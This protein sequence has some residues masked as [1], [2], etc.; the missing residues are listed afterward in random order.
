MG[1]RVGFDRLEQEVT[2]PLIAHWNQNHYVVVYAIKNEKVYVADPA[3]GKVVYTKAEFIKCWASTESNDLPVGICLILE[4]TPNFYN[5]ENEDPDKS[6][7]SF[8]FKYLKPHKKFIIQL[9]LGFLVGSILQLFFPFL[10]QAIVDIGINTHNISFIWLILIAQLMLFISRLSMEF[11]R[12]WIIL[13]VSTRINISL[14]SDF[15]IKLM[16]LPIRF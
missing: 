1:I 12:S 8:L 10:T 3:Y 5:I 11:I 16:R 9:F 13:H 6:G 14:I 4:P 7:F 2:L 15:L